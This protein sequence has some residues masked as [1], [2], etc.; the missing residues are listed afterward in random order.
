MRIDNS[1]VANNE[2]TVVALYLSKGTF[3]PVPDN[4]HGLHVL[5][6]EG[7]MSRS[8]EYLNTQDPTRYGTAKTKTA[9]VAQVFSIIP[10]RWGPFSAEN[11]I[12]DHGKGDRIFRRRWHVYV[13]HPKRAGE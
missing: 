11:A 13:S 3:A 5:Y 2:M 4:E 10:E 6:Q 1:L 9:R 7:L 8:S 12:D